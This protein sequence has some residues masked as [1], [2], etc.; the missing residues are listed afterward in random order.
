KAFSGSLPAS[1]TTTDLFIQD[2][3]GW[4]RAADQQ[5]PCQKLPSESR[6]GER[7]D[8]DF[9]LGEGLLKPMPICF[10][11]GAVER[12]RHDLENEDVVMHRRS[13]GVMVAWVAEI[14]E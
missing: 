3:R 5:M 4:C 2:L 6:D 12:I 13:L 11:P 8:D 10:P 1:A 9:I 14:V 7:K